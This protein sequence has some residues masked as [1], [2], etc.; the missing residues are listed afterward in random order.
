[1][2]SA[3]AASLCSTVCFCPRLSLVAVAVP[4]ACWT[5][6]GSDACFH[7]YVFPLWPN[8]FLCLELFS[9]CF[10]MCPCQIPYVSMSSSICKYVEQFLICYRFPSL[11]L[12]VFHTI[13]NVSVYVK[14][15]LQIKHIHLYSVHTIYISQHVFQD[16]SISSPHYFTY[17][18]TFSEICLPPKCC[19]P[20]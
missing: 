7:M 1:M 11:F 13:P 5:I 9:L 3:L 10:H 19:I 18:D 17:P 14:F 12:C 20:P 16:W 6:A 2:C 8:M 4:F 15:V